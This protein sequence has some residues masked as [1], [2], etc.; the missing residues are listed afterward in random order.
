MNQETFE[1]PGE[2]SLIQPGGPQGYFWGII[3]SSGPGWIV[4][5]QVGSEAFARLIIREHNRLRQEKP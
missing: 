5:M 3:S 1:D 2:W 4:A